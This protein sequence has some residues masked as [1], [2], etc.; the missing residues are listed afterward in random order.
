[1]SRQTACSWRT[2]EGGASRLPTENTLPIPHLVRVLHRDPGERLKVLFGDGRDHVVGAPRHH[3]LR[4]ELEQLARLHPSP[5]PDRARHLLPRV[6]RHA[7][8][9]TQL[10]IE[11]IC[12]QLLR[13]VAKS[14][15]FSYYLVR[16]FRS[17][18]VVGPRELLSDGVFAVLP[19]AHAPPHEAAVHRP[20]RRP[21]ALT[22]ELAD[23]ALHSVKPAAVRRSTFFVGLPW[24]EPSDICSLFLLIKLSKG[25]FWKMFPEIGWSLLRPS[26]VRT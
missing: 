18:P 26:T 5:H 3:L 22:R 2:R 16:S 12:P 19:L 8:Q 14:L 11:N 21:R 4:P 15:D 1:M 25:R 6:L 9:H 10:Y 23:L 20:A 24:F 13:P 7:D 17:W